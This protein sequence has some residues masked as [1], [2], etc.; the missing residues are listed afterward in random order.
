MSISSTKD[1]VLSLQRSTAMNSV[2]EHIFSL[3]QKTTVTEDNAHIFL[4]Q[5]DDSLNSIN[6]RL[7]LLSRPS[8]I[9]VELSI[10]TRR[11]F[12][13]R[14]ENPGYKEML[15]VPAFDY[16][17]DSTKSKTGYGFWNR[18]WRKAFD[19]RP[20]HELW[21]RFDAYLSPGSSLR[22]INEIDRSSWR[23]RDGFYINVNST[24]G[25][26]VV[27]GSEAAFP[28]M[29]AGFHSFLA[30]FKSGITDGIIQLWCDDE[31]SPLSER[32]GNVRKG[33]IIDDFFIQSDNGSPQVFV[34]NLIISNTKLS[35]SDE[36]KVIK[37]HWNQ[38]TLTKNGEFGKD[39]CAVKIS[40]GGDA[41]YHIFDNGND[42]SWRPLDYVDFY[43]KNDIKINIMQI[44]FQERN[45][46]LNGM[47]LLGSNNY[48]DFEEICDFGKMRITQYCLIIPNVPRYLYYR[49]TGGYYNNI[50]GV[51]IDAVTDEP[52]FFIDTYRQGKY[53]TVFSEGLVLDGKT[54]YMQVPI[55]VTDA[56]N[57]ATEFTIKTTES[58]S[59][60]RIWNSPCIFGCET[61]G[62]NSRDFLVEI[63]S[64]NL[65]IF[66]GLGNTKDP[67]GGTL[68]WNIGEA[69]I[70]T[71]IKIN[72]GELHTIRMKYEIGKL[73]VYCDRV[74]ATEIYPSYTLLSD[75]LYF[76]SSFPS[77]KAFASLE[78]YGAKIWRQGELVAEYSPSIKQVTDNKLYDLSGKN[79]HAIL[80]GDPIKTV[81]GQ[82]LSVDTS[83]HLTCSKMLGIS[84]TLV[85]NIATSVRRIQNSNDEYSMLD[86]ASILKTYKQ[87]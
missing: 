12:H 6:E 4:L 44:I 80:Y 21:I 37:G 42:S 26:S 14:Y 1:S 75:S 63:K 65:Y 22:V 11:D 76:G 9:D 35:L 68:T 30:H 46:N 36:C 38:P 85:R 43:M 53:T 8:G 84:E 20:T 83:R 77:T 7:F 57:W 87:S 47:R 28:A 29:N 19:I 10:D 18:Y 31:E 60:D 15:I 78:L 62:G 74:L 32:T 41:I 3:Q 69:G 61:P 51:I 17:L 45:Y 48:Q 39:E 70:D 52:T 5:K 66:N 40:D 34:S 71:G 2:N 16:Q 55:S 33:E 49:I 67:V 64:G 54:N 24:G 23:D 58:R 86:V 81:E 79:N 59:G 56:A 27:S 72:D 25:R 73:Q 50:T 13:W 82:V